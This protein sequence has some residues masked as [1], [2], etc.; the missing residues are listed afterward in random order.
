MDQIGTGEGA[1]A[2]GHG[3]YFADDI[4]EAKRYQPRDY[5][6][7]EELY[8]LYKEAE[9]AGDQYMMDAWERAMMQDSPIEL[10]ASA[11]DPDYDEYSQAAFAEVADYLESN[12]GQGSLLRAEIDVT[13]E[14]MIDW[15]KSL[16]EQPEF[17]EALRKMGLLR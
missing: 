17:N 11:A 1:Q 5:D 13:P 15:E 8:R 6:Q 3:L 14:S 2:Y 9:E 4:D 10:R 16:K 12:P 7:E